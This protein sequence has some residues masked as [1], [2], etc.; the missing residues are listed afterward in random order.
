M[1]LNVL[2][3]DQARGVWG[4]Q[5]YLLRLAPLLRAHG[6]EMTLGCP[7]EL[8]LFE[9]WQKAGFTAFDVS[10]PIVR[11]IRN[12]GQPQTMDIA[13]ESARG[14]RS[15][16]LI[17]RLAIKT[18]ADTIWANAH[19]IHVEAS[20]AGRL[21]GKPTVLHL[22]EEAI[23]GLGQQ[24][25]T[26]AVRLAHRTVAV[27]AAVARGVPAGARRRV[28]VI[29][30]GVDTAVMSP[31]DDGGASAAELR[32]RL[33]VSAGEVMVLA[34]TRLDPVKRI[35]D[36]ITTVRIAADPRV[37]LVI[38]GETTGFPDY[39]REMHTIA[40]SVGV[41]RITFCGVREDM[42]ELF[43]AADIVL[44]AGMV[45]GMPLGLVEAQACGT[46]VV[47]YAVAGVP[48]AVTDGVTGILAAAA[49]VSGLAAALGKLAGDSQMRAQMGAAG[50]EHVLT[51]HRIERQARR[52]ADVIY[53]MCGVPRR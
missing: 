28:E 6:I 15:A 11:S 14:F 39:A 37:H 20:L 35:E 12:D 5:R 18:R 17:G 27:S 31:S 30:N 13:R 26:T 21:T 4:A 2:V 32:A 40:R 44:H 10:L 23:P 19:W 41:G 53:E 45:E 8:E 52:N 1:P 38:A 33:G 29:A 25:R 50:R 47:A 7:A 36:L 51:D 9:A 16:A 24:I 49:D 22:H 43:R 48:E 3:L 42:P 34:A 46:P